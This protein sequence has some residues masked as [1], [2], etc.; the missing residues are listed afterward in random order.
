M[1]KASSVIQ[2]K[3]SLTES[4]NL[5]KVLGDIIAD[6]PFCLSKLKEKKNAGVDETPTG[7]KAPD[8]ITRSPQLPSKGVDIS[9]LCLS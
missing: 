3:D 2:S 1:L 6:C 4:N 5:L 8:D 9:S 7:H